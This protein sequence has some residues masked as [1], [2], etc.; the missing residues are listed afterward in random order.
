MGPHHLWGMHVLQLIVEIPGTPLSQA[1][2]LQQEDPAYLIPFGIPDAVSLHTQSKVG[3]ASIRGHR[4]T[5]V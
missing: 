3:S 4:Q 1:P 5:L 2:K